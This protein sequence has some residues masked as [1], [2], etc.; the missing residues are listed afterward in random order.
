MSKITRFEEL[1][2]WKAARLL[3]KTVYAV[4]QSGNIAKDG[5]ACRQF[6]RA[7]V[8]IMNNIAEG[9]G[10]FSDKD[11]IRFLDT[12]KASGYEVK[13][14]LYLFEDVNY[15]PAETLTQLHQEVNNALHLTGGFIRYLQKRSV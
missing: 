4:T 3:T 12:A 13:S 6:R 14:M 9:F 1:D 7:S 10:R 2:C 15:L 8:S 5:D 11:S